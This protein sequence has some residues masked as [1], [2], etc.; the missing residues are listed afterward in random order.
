[1]NW[2]QVQGKW[3]QVKGSARIEW[4]KLT[5]QDVEKIAGERDKLVGLIEEKYGRT[6]EEAEEE[7]DSWSRRV[8]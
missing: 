2:E 3:D 5:D 6:K 1:M 8:A 4:A 7:V